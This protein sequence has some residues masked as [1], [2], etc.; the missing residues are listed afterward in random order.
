MKAPESLAALLDYGII[1]EVLAPLM[2]GKEAQIYLVVSEGQERVAVFDRGDRTV[3]RVPTLDQ[4]LLRRQARDH[5][6]PQGSATLDRRLL[7]LDVV[8]GRK[9]GADHQPGADPEHTD[10]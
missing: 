8:G 6:A 4:Q 2:S 7:A 3:N 1:Q 10:L 9:L 5:R